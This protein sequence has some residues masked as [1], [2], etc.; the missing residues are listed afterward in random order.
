MPTKNQ[1]APR[2]QPIL[3]RSPMGR[4]ACQ[5]AQLPLLFDPEVE[6]AVMEATPNEHGVLRGHMITHRFA[7]ASTRKLYR[8][9]RYLEDYL[10]LDLAR[11]QGRWYWA[12]SC[13]CNDLAWSSPISLRWPRQYALSFSDA[14]R[15][16]LTTGMERIRRE[17]FARYHETSA[18]AQIARKLLA[19]ASAGQYEEIQRVAP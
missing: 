10:Q 13:C 2:E 18:H 5:I 16:A 4:K 6:P 7:M 9:D 19:M 1:S 11:F 15:A 17:V 8:S 3:F 14:R 12:D